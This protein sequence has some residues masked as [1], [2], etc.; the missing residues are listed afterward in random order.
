MKILNLVFIA[1]LFCVSLTFA[2]ERRFSASV[3]GGVGV[4][5]SPEFFSD[6]WGSGGNFSV[7][8][9]YSVN[10]FFQI[11]VQ[12][13]WSTFGF[14]SGAFKEEDNLLLAVYEV[15]LHAEIETAIKNELRNEFGDAVAD[16][17]V[18]EVDT[19]VNISVNYSGLD[20]SVF[21]F[22]P[23]VRLAATT[24]GRVVPYVQVGVGYFRLSK[25]TGVVRLES[26]VDVFSEFFDVAFSLHDEVEEPVSAETE[27]ALGYF[28]GVGMEVSLTSSSSFAIDV[29]WVAGDVVLGVVGEREDDFVSFIPVSLSYIYKW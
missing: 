29:G 24:L 5:N 7:G 20:I 18:D 12:S 16:A 10:E 27:S 17:V 1:L 28:A 21:T 3:G 19:D 4:P 22:I 2:Q 6:R 11:G 23:S 8:F 26:D 14:N 13:G 15:V 9:N 25:K